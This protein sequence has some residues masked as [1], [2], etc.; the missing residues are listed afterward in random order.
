MQTWVPKAPDPP[1]LK[2]TGTESAM[3]IHTCWNWGE[4]NVFWISSAVWGRDSPEGR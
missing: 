4:V 2:D 1:K 3:D